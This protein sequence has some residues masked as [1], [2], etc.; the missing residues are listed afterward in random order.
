[1]HPLSTFPPH[2]PTCQQAPRIPSPAPSLDKHGPHDKAN[3][4]GRKHLA[5]PTS[6]ASK[7]FFSSTA[8]EIST[9]G[10]PAR[11]T[12]QISNLAHPSRFPTSRIH[13]AFFKSALS[14]A[15]YTFHLFSHLRRVESAWLSLGSGFPGSKNDFWGVETRAYCFA[16][17]LK[18]KDGIRLA[19][20]PSPS[21]PSPSTRLLP[22]A[23]PN[24]PPTHPLRPPTLPSSS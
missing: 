7:S 11:E 23:L 24:I 19:S 4:A 20:P 3:V 18:F 16:L 12:V 1:M 10:P 14:I 15:P 2:Y 9:S 21:P 5:H 17:R 6:L 13:P 8:A 22:P